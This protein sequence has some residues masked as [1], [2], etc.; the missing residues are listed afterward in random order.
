MEKLTIWQAL[1]I[2]FFS[3][4]I[5]VSLGVGL[6]NILDHFLPERAPLTQAEKDIL[7]PMCPQCML[8]IERQEA[9]SQSEN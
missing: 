4:T 9:F 2:A 1:F 3:T 7:Y 8:E 6:G 5:G